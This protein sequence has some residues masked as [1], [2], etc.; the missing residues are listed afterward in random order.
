MLF[1]VIILFEIRAVK[2]EILLLW[3]LRTSGFF[4]DFLRSVAIYQLRYFE[5]FWLRPQLFQH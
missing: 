4:T 3:A 5:I 2:S 1:I